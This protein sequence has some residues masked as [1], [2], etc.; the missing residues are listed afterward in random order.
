MGT[1]RNFSIFLSKD[2]FFLFLFKS[3]LDFKKTSTLIKD[4]LFSRLNYL[5]FASLAFGNPSQV[6]KSVALLLWL[7]LF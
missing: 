2:S 4:C 3:S 5:F 7:K 6:F 1:F